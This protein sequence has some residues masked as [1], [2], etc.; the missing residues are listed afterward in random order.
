MM[1]QRAR[2][3]EAEEK[4]ILN[5]LLQCFPRFC[6]VSNECWEHNQP[7]PPDFVGTR[8]KGQLSEQKVGL[9]L[10]EWLEGRAAASS[11][12]RFSMRKDL[13]RILKFPPGWE[14]RNYKL[15]YV[16]PHWGRKISESDRISLGDEFHQACKKV[17]DDWNSPR[18]QYG[19]PLTGGKDK[20]SICRAQNGWPVIAGEYFPSLQTL[21]KYVRAIRFRTKGPSGISYICFEAMGGIQSPEEA[22]AALEKIIQD[23]TEKYARKTSLLSTRQFDELVLLIHSGAKRAILNMSWEL[24]FPD[25]SA[26]L[27]SIVEKVNGAARNSRFDSIWLL[28]RSLDAKDENGE[29]SW[30]AQIFPAENFR[31]VKCALAAANSR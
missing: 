30:L 22:L 31:L 26:N 29:D 6:G 7:D 23:K 19:W 3:K 28:Q 17:D 10:S 16:T 12:G 24:D 11:M 2:K 14:P 5:N 18:P 25:L 8:Q 4:A 20:E 9:E 21:N 27:Q 1:K 15:I 13:H